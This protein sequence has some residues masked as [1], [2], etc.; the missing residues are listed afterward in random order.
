[1]QDW[2]LLLTD[3]RL[4]TVVSDE[5]TS[6]IDAGALAIADGRIAWAGCVHELPQGRALRT[7]ALEGRWVTPGFIDCHTHLV[8]AGNRANEFAKRMAG[9]SYVDI[10]AAG[11]GIKATVAATRAASE[12]Q[13]LVNAALRL[14]ALLAE[15]VTTVEIKSGYGMDRDT[16]LRM[17]ATARRLGEG[18]PVTIVTTYLGGHTVPAEFAGNRAGYVDLVCRTMLEVASARLADAVDV[19][20]DPIGFDREECERML[21]AAHRAGLPLKLHTGQL[22]AQGGGAFAAS[23]GALSADHV[24]YLSED[25]VTAMARSGTVAVLLPGAFYYLRETRKPPVELLRRYGVPI[26]VA[27]DH[28]PGS[29]PLLSIVLAMNM[30]SVFFGLTAAETL[31]GVTRNAARALGLLH[32]RGTIET[33]KRADL[34]IWDI[35]ELGELASLIGSRKPSM[36]IQN[37]RCVGARTE[38]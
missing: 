38:I 16:E 18:K 2:D 33:G 12:S 26:A 1:M 9:A 28:N 3:A 15:G 19:C 6:T 17:L 20:Y 32:D 24:E 11:G 5:P 7:I 4:A 36:V 21:Q 8:Y 29:S 35:G 34:A 37:G 10:A 23:H 30:A 14:D 27:T 25:D 31:A 13:L 22:A